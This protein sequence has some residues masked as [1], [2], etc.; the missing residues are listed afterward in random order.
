MRLHDRGLRL[1]VAM[2]NM[3]VSDWTPPPDL[4]K[5]MLVVVSRELMSELLSTME[6]YSYILRVAVTDTQ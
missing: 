2:I 1:T 5:A 4:W 3:P 6:S